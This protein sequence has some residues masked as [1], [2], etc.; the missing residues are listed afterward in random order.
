MLGNEP[1]QSKAD[2]IKRAQTSFCF[3]SFI[4]SL[5]VTHKE[6]RTKDD[7]SARQEVEGVAF[8]FFLTPPP[9]VKNSYGT[10]NK[11]QTHKDSQQEVVTRLH[12]RQRLDITECDLTPRE[13]ETRQ[14][15]PRRRR[16]HQSSHVH[17]ASPTGLLVSSAQNQKKRGRFHGGGAEHVEAQQHGRHQCLHQQHKGILGGWGRWAVG[18]V[19]GGEQGRGMGAGKKKKVRC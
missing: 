18:E 6:N 16:Q 5:D 14:K 7:T 3:F 15:E 2:R 19:A 1:R 8:F 4:G 9:L 11:T 10:D 17:Q 12:G 13:T